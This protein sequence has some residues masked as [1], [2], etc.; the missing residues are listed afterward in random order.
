MP[1]T[2]RD[3]ARHAGVGVGTVSRV[4]NG[5][6]AVS[7]TTRHKVLTAIEDLNYVP[8]SM[9]RRL[10]LG[11][12]MTVGVLAPFFTRPSVVE[13][14]RGIESVLA[15]TQY[16]LSLFNVETMSRRENCFRDIFRRERVDGLLIITLIPTEAE[17]KRLKK[18][19]IPT[20]LV[21]ADS[22]ALHSIAID[23]VYG[24]RLATTHL[25]SLGHRRIGFISHYLE[26]DFGNGSS[27]DRFIGYSQALA[28]V[29]LAVRPDYVHEGDADRE[30]AYVMASKMLVLE[31]RP[32]A[33]FAASDAQAI[34]IL[35]A[36]QAFNLSVPEDLSVIGYDDIE[37]AEYINLTTVHQPLMQSG[38]QGT[39]MLLKIMRDE[40]DI[41]QQ[42]TLPIHIVP[43]GTTAP[44]STLG[45]VPL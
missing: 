29:G 44:P 30:A 45:S 27:K 13:R 17:T 34:G 6:T 41:P 22:D 20:V 33:I 39:E 32:T 14:L 40:D 4:L 3:V 5:S 42:V 11:R 36:A 26:D 28:E 35:K 15:T 18:A 25:L 10:S 24:G 16:D 37:L 12:T 8:N 1:S 19:N 2:I 7:E 9:A 21:D 43:R 38:T 23:D 31:D